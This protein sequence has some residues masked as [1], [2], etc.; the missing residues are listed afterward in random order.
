MAGSPSAAAGS[1]SK[2]P[3]LIV[4]DN[5]ANRLAFG[6]VLAPLGVDVVM[7]SSG[8]EALARIDE[9]D[10]AVILLDVRMPIMDGY[11]TAER[12]RQR[13][14]T[15]YTPIIFTSA[16]DMSP[17]QVTKAYVAGAIDYIPSPVDSDVLTLKVSAYIQLYLRDEAVL[18]ALR[19]LTMCYEA[20]QADMA[21]SQGIS[22]GLQA[23]LKA[24]EQTI[25]RLREELD[26]CT[27]GCTPSVSSNATA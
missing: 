2:I 25:H 27:C 15:K 21:A 13:K 17:A 6:T 12:I 5:A 3:V 22:A 7:A 14:S 9:R 16:F 20:L 10:F 26:R 19:D 18:R 11:E 4:D 8:K 1:A 23:K 24:M